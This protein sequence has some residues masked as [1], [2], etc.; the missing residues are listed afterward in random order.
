MH[1]SYNQ[2]VP[3]TLISNCDTMGVAAA[4]SIRDGVL[5]GNMQLHSGLWT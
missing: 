5:T 3:D 4:Y 1:A 2:Q